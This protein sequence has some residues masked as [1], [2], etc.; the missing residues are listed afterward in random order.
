MMG[1]YVDAW[2]VLMFSLLLSMWA[3]TMLESWKRQEATRE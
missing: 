1:G 3:V 2:G